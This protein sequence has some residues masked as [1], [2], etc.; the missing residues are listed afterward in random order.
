MLLI[1]FIGISYGRIGIG[2]AIKPKSIKRKKAS[3][4]AG[5]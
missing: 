1:S 3:Y 2:K 5:F 4:K